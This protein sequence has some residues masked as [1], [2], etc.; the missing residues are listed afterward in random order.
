MEE[1][2]E[3]PWGTYQTIL[4][5]ETYQVNKIVVFH[6]SQFSLNDNS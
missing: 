6:N 4:R 1:I 3:R 2:V 5:G